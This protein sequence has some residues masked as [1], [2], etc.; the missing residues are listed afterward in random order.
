MS[1]RTVTAT[2]FD[3]TEHKAT[4]EYL[5]L[6]DRVAFERKFG[7]STAILSK[8]ASLFDDK[9]TLKDDADLSDLE[10]NV[11]EQHSFLS[12]RLL[13]R[14]GCDVGD[15]DTFIDACVNI[16]VGPKEDG[17]VDPTIAEAQPGN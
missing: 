14:G 6:A 4:G 2:M 13:S 11:A 9:G 12:W 16:E 7:I 5:A 8:H 1:R 10:G 17:G 3:G 15:F